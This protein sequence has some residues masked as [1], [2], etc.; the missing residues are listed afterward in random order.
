MTI[1]YRRLYDTPQ[2]HIMNL[3]PVSTTAANLEE[4]NMKHHKKVTKDTNALGAMKVKAALE[5]AQEIEI[6][7]IALRNGHVDSECADLLVRGMTMR[8]QSLAC[9][10]ASAVSIDCDVN[11]LFREIGLGEAA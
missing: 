7:A 11:E 5:A 4:T 1:A 2:K 9:V 10:V 8:I 6:L 3:P